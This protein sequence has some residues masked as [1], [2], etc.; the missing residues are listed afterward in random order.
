MSINEGLLSKFARKLNLTSGKKVIGNFKERLAEKKITTE[1]DEYGNVEYFFN[2]QRIPDGELGT[3]EL[4]VIYLEDGN[5]YNK[6][7]GAKMDSNAL[8][9]IDDWIVY[10]N[11][12]ATKSGIARSI[13][14]VDE[15]NRVEKI[16]NLI[17]SLSAVKDEKAY[18]ET[19]R[20]IFL[21]VSDLDSKPTKE[22]EKVPTK[23][24]LFTKIGGAATHKEPDSGLSL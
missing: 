7:N 9:K 17:K 10:C 16:N 20:K 21:Q 2:G 15:I 13:G 24:S 14:G 18:I 19:R 1:I 8:R 11:E 23:N 5:Y 4:H 12:T 3:K 22:Y 6:N